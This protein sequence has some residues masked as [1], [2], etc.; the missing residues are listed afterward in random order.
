MAKRKNK[1]GGGANALRD[2]PRRS[3]C[4][5]AS[6][7]DDGAD[8]DALAVGGTAGIVQADVI[9]LRAQ[10]QVRQNTDINAAANAIGEVGRGTAG[11]SE[12]CG[13]MPSTCKKLN[14]GSEIRWVVHDDARAEEKRVRVEGNAAG[15]GVVA[16]EITDDTQVG[17]GFVGD[18]TADTVLIEVCAAAEVEVGVADGS[19][20][21]L[22]ARRNGE[23]DHRE[24]K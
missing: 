4:A 13:Q 20:G 9:E 17:D 23:D 6:E 8:R 15:G 3:R 5:S 1:W 22:C 11:S 10:S 19:V 14:K 2:P 21:G 12:A 24:A 18:G 16:A 7:A